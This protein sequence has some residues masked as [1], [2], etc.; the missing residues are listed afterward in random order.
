MHTHCMYTKSPGP[1]RVHPRGGGGRQQWDT[2]ANAMLTLPALLLVIKSFVSD[3]G[4]SR[5]LAD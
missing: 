3:L 2:S 5:L 1:L 4:V